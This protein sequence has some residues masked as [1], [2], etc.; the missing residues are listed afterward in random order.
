MINNNKDITYTINKEKWFKAERF[1][2]DELA[3][4]FYP[5]LLTE[6]TILKMQQF[7]ID[8]NTR[9]TRTEKDLVWQIKPR[10]LFNLATQEFGIEPDLDDGK[11]KLV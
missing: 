2:N 7:L 11:F 1:Y 6:S 5:M 8:L 9:I 4:K 3:K 10:L